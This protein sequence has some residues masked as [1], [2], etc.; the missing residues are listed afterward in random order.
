MLSGSKVSL[1][2]KLVTTTT[3][4]PCLGFSQESLNRRWGT[5]DAVGA[6]ILWPHPGNPVPLDWI[7]LLI[8]SSRVLKDWLTYQISGSIQEQVMKLTSRKWCNKFTGNVQNWVPH[9]SPFESNP[10]LPSPAS[11]HLQPSKCGLLPNSSSDCCASL[12]T[13]YGSDWVDPTWP[14][15]HM[16]GSRNRKV[17]QGWT[18]SYSS[19]LW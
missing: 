3:L 17:C 7:N 2:C 4:R 1:R 8:K 9:L 15:V 19:Y 14:G 10:P 11:V 5:D 18:R 13:L 12:R 16:L 6:F